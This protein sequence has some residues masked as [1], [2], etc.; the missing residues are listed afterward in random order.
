MSR[1]DG[2]PSW[3][4]VAGQVVV[5]AGDAAAEAE[6]WGLRERAGQG[7]AGNDLSDLDLRE[8]DLFG[9]SLAGGW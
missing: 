1:F 9:A 7:P 6:R 8:A 5:R 4:L 2:A 3:E